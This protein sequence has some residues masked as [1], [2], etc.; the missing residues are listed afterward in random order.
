M[1]SE[2]KI[3]IKISDFSKS[4]DWINW[5][6]SLNFKKLEWNGGIIVEYYL[7]IKGDGDDP[8]TDVRLSVR[9]GDN[10]IDRKK[11][12]G[13]ACIMLMMPGYMYYFKHVR[14][15]SEFIMLYKLLTGKLLY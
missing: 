7:P 3:N 13:E 8:Y 4:K 10:M 15:P 11:L 2:I 6:E 5:C 12:N 1:S 14:Y 9:I